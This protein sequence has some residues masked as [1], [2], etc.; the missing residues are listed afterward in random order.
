MKSKQGRLALALASLL[1]A[2][3]VWAQTAPE[4]APTTAPQTAA[5]AGPG[6]GMGPGMGPRAGMGRGPCMQADTPRP[7]CGW[8][9]NRRNSPGFAL[10]TPEERGAHQERMRN[11]QSREECVAYLQEHHAQMGERAKAKGQTLPQPRMRPCD[12]LPSAAGR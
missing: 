2:G 5:P 12:R 7:N 10:M 1:L 3:S 11:F 9:M 8:R 4:T 6:M